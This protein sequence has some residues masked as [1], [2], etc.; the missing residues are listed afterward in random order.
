MHKKNLLQSGPMLGYTDMFETM[1]W[2]QTKSA[3]KVQFVYWPKGNAAQ[4]FFTESTKTRQADGY[5][6]HLTADRVQPGGVYE[7]ELRINDQP[8]QLDYPTVFQ[9]Q[10]L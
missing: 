3:A 1:L 2:M 4:K 5:T 9:T 10:T 6:A 8:V 7:Y